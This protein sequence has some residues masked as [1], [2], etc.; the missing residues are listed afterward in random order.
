VERAKPSAVPFSQKILVTALPFVTITTGSTMNNRLVLSRP[1]L[2]DII[3]HLVILSSSHNGKNKVL[4]HTAH[5]ILI[6]YEM[7]CEHQKIKLAHH[8]SSQLNFYGYTLL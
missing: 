7:F 3:S 2:V 4:E 1:V 6:F 5:C 8:C